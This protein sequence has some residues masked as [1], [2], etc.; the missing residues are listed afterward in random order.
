M[1][2]MPNMRAVRVT[3]RGTHLQNAW[4]VDLGGPRWDV[5]V[6]TGEEPLLMRAAPARLARLL[7]RCAGALRRGG[8]LVVEPADDVVQQA[9]R[10]VDGGGDGVGP[11]YL[12][13]VETATGVFE[14]VVAGPDVP[15]WLHSQTW[16]DDARLTVEPISTTG[17][18]TRLSRS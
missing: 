10:D 2:V 6:L 11:T 14:S 5:V 15:S 7:R 18:P 12:V 3:A 17:G 4:H 16:P 8:R 9:L 1:M 13:R